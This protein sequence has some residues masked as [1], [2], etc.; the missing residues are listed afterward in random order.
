M[1]T[2]KPKASRMNLEIR[3]YPGI[4][5][6]RTFKGRLVRFVCMLFLTILKPIGNLGKSIFKSVDYYIM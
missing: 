4:K 1:L 6:L 3:P 2:S 5:A